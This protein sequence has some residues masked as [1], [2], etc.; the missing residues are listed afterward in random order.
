VP[1]IEDGIR[2]ALLRGIISGYPVR[3]VRV[4]LV[5]GCYHDVDSTATAFRIA[6]SRAVREALFMAECVVLEPLMRLNIHVPAA[7]AAGV[8]ATVANR[9]GRIYR[10]SR[11]DVYHVVA[12]APLAELFGF[13]ADLASLTHGH[14]TCEMEFAGYAPLQPAGGDDEDRDALVTSPRK[15][16]PPLRQLGVALPEPEDIDPEQ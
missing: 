1:T 13:A 7:S 3:G 8:L 6:A 14:A 10:S 15:P 5:D 16:L 11:G 12:R 4:D 2:E 9:R